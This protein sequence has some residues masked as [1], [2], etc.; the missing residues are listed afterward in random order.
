MNDELALLRQKIDS[1]DEEILRALSERAQCA[2]RIG[3]LKEGHLYRAEREAQV[4]R[5][6]AELN[7]GPLN[8]AVVQT[9]FREIMSACLALEQTLSVAYLGPAGTFSEQACQKHFGHAPTALPQSSIEEVFRAVQGKQA[10]YGVVPLENSTEGA[11]GQTLDL[12]LAYPLSVCGEV[13]LRIHQNL[14]CHPDAKAP[15]V[16]VYS[17]P[18]S[19][20]QC[21]HWL[22]RHHPQIER[23]PVSSNAEAARQ[24]AQDP[25]ACAIAGERAATAYGLICQAAHIEDQPNNTTRFAVI[26]THDAGPSGH[27]K[28]SL[29]CS[30]PNRPGA[31]HTLLEPFARHGIDMSRLESRPSRNGL[32]EYVFYIDVQGHRE[33]PALAL[34]LRELEAR[35]AFLKV[36]GSYPVAVF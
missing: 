13:V 7:P 16:R 8:D 26:A 1:L 9:L 6:L 21:H 29:V 18:Q 3:Q 28:T 19:L 32:W 10:D 27:D 36:L 14:L 15:F 33:T 4:L 20:A 30:A 12:L 35:S 11:V 25:Q 31:V 34:A 24:A 5:R 22:S 23:V 17:H 2:K